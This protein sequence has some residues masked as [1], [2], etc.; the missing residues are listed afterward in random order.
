MWLKTE[1]SS[2]VNLDNGT[3]LVVQQTESDGYRVVAY[4]VQGGTAIARGGFPTKELAQAELDTMMA[5][6]DYLFIQP[7]TTDEEK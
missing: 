3:R 5:E 6:N 2:Y 1:V 4:L 7:P